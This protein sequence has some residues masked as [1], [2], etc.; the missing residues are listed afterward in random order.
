MSKQR[1][2]FVCMVFLLLISF[3][4]KAQFYLGIEAGGNKN[5]LITNNSAQSFTT[6]NSASGISIG[7]PVLYQFNEWFALQASPSYTQ[8]NYQINRTGFFQGIYQKNTNG[9]IQLP[10][11]GN[12]SFGGEQLRGY[13][14]LGV[15]GAYWLS[16]NV[17]G[18]EPNIL[19]PNDTA[20]SSSNPSSALNEN[21]GY[22][23]N[24]K[25]TFS[26]IKDNRL[27]LGWV[28]G[29]GISYEVNSSYRFFIE[30]KYT[31]SFTDQQKK[32]QTNQVPRYNDTFGISIG[33]L[34]SLDNLFGSFY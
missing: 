24:E 14:N 23:Y 7:I 2:G 26:S 6:Y 9:Y 25:Y 28:A 17:K 12:F 8:K 29:M 15:Y 3:T 16:G 34:F 10:I 22:T 31:G 1:T 21:Y 30:G 19:N 33:C 18:T 13:A 4:S 27:E 5:Y 32:Y 11:M 20:Y